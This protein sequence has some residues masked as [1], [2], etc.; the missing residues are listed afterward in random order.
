MYSE[1]PELTCWTGPLMRGPAG[2]LLRKAVPD[3]ICRVPSVL[4]RS[5]ARVGQSLTPALLPVMW[6]RR[7]SQPSAPQ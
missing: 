4:L 1:R 5:K 7:K 6:T 2:W 3:V